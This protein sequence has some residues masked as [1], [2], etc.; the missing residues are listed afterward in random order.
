M[1]GFYLV[2]LRSSG[3]G[4]M[5]DRT[6]ESIDDFQIMYA[7]TR[8]NQYQDSYPPHIPRP[9]S[10]Y[11]PMKAADPSGSNG[12]P[13]LHDPMA[14]PHYITAP[15]PI[16]SLQTYSPD[17]DLPVNQR[18][19]STHVGNGSVSEAPEDTYIAMD[20]VGTPSN[21]QRL[22]AISAGNQSN[23]D[24]RLSIC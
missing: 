21:Q 19:K 12:Y 9:E 1:D 8:K 3:V 13:T 10:P 6:Y 5:Q 23:G 20:R 2:G 16:M 17:N 14:S 15:Y 18:D 22:S 11:Q 4:E 24:Y 7:N